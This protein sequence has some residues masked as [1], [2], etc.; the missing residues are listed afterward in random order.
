MTFDFFSELT[1]GINQETF[2][3]QVP[4]QGREPRVLLW[5]DDKSDAIRKL[6]QQKDSV[7]C[8]YANCLAGVCRYAALV[9]Q[10]GP[11]LRDALRSNWIAGKQVARDFR[12][13]APP[14]TPTKNAPDRVREI[15]SPAIPLCLGL[16]CLLEIKFTTRTPWF[17]RAETDFGPVDN[18]VCKDPTLGLPEVRPTSWKGHLSTM[19]K[20]EKL[21][22]RPGA[23]PA[24]ARDSDP[25]LLRL[26]GS[27]NVD[28]PEKAHMGRLVFFP[29][30]FD[31]IGGEV[32]TPHDRKTKTATRGPIFFEVV[33][34]GTSGTVSVLYFPFDLLL[35]D[36][37]IQ[38]RE[39]QDDLKL[40][41]DALPR[42][43]TEVGFSA[44]SSV[45]WG[46]AKHPFSSIRV[47]FGR[48]FD[49][50]CPWLLGGQDATGKKLL[51]RLNEVKLRGADAGAA[52]EPCLPG[53]EASQ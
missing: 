14:A 27:E 11:G 36:T 47:T 28:K 50:E 42:L 52:G 4:R 38:Q 5:D 48:R 2:T 17:S 32:V 18:M 24:R 43:L 41:F 20:M 40:L 22:K 34:P 19:L 53:T 7:P 45:G 39:V 44:K 15:L 8:H 23:D 51:S 31:K 25:V 1:Q 26:F 30:F 10:L 29:T 49:I 46:L 13:E 16:S 9:Q 3:Y 37:N 21:K 33:P 35:K 6:N 12:W